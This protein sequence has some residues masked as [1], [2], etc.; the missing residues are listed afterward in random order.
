MCYARVTGRASRGPR[1]GRLVALV[2]GTAACWCACV[3]SGSAGGSA[4]EEQMGSVGDT[5]WP[6]GLACRCS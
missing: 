5:A 1:R 2:V 6:T 4:V 3:S